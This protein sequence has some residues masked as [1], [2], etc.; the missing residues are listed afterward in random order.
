[1]NVKFEPSN[2]KKS[3]ILLY[4]LFR[5]DLLEWEEYKRKARH[6]R[7]QI[8]LRKSK[9]TSR[10]SMNATTPSY[11]MVFNKTILAF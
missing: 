7:Y 10:T 9:S 2:T 4:L 6:S 1:M 8:L 11:K 5:S 3:L